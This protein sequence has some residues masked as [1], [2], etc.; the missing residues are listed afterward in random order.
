[1]ESHKDSSLLKMREIVLHYAKNGKP[2]IIDID[3]L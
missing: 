3:E 2:E 1:M